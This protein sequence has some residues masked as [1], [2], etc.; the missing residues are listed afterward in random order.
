M[1]TSSGPY[2]HDAAIVLGKGV[3]DP[4]AEMLH[5]TQHA[6]QMV[7]GF[8]GG[9]NLRDPLAPGTPGGGVLREHASTAAAAASSARRQDDQVIDGTW[10]ELPDDRPRRP[11]GWT[12]H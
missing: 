3:R 12:K 9:A 4:R 5:E 10:E 11:S 2:I 7:E 6:L 8:K 1:F